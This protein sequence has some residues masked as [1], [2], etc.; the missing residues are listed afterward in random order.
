MPIPAKSQF[1]NIKTERYVI[2]PF[3]QIPTIFACDEQRRCILSFIQYHYTLR[4]MLLLIA[5][6]CN[7]LRYAL[8]YR[9]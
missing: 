9:F 3:L 8:P 2:N 7:R 1:G 4:Y 5:P 6:F